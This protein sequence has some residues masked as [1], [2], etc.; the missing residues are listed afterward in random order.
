M[1][2]LGCWVRARST[3]VLSKRKL[4]FLKFYTSKHMCNPKQDPL[5]TVAVSGLIIGLR[6]PAKLDRGKNKITQGYAFGRKLSGR[7]SYINIHTHIN[8]DKNES[9][10]QY[11]YT[12]KKI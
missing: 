11:V 7:T 6:R 3:V 12:D 10:Y 8:I 2:S 1:T 5:K 4:W 9:K